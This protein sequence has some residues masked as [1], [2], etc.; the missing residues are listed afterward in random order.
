M[1]SV[2]RST[3]EW[4]SVAPPASNLCLQDNWVCINSMLLYIA[5]R[6]VAAMACSSLCTII[7]NRLH[8]F[9]Y[10]VSKDCISRRNG[11]W[12]WACWAVSSERASLSGLAGS[13]P[14]S[15]LW[16]IFLAMMQ[17]ASDDA[18]I[19]ERSKNGCWNSI[20]RLKISW[21]MGWFGI[22][23]KWYRLCNSFRDEGLEI[24]TLW[25]VA[26]H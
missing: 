7:F 22:R 14:T 20:K 4:L 26:G 3:R 2:V 5:V 21:E 13:R 6:Q 19:D 1:W 8:I 23:G 12:A 9:K 16:K 15:W 11:C 25:C 17:I 10:W 18:F 24:L